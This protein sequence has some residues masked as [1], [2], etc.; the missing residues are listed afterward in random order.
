M[1]ITYVG[2]Q[3]G[4]RAGSTSTTNIT[5]ALSGGS[6]TTP[7]AGDLVVIGCAVGSQGRTP[8][9]AISGYTAG[10]QQDANGTTYDTSLNK[11]Y[12]F[13]GLTPDTTFTLP[14][15]G[16]I[17]DAQRYTVQVW[18]GVDPANPFD[19]ADVVAT[20]TATGRPNPGSITPTT[21]GAVVGIIGAGAAGTGAAYTAPANYTTNFLTGTTADTN[22]AMIGSG[23]RSWTSGAE[24][25][26]AYTGGTTN[27]ADSWAAFT[28]ALRPEVSYEPTLI[29][30]EVVTLGQVAS[31][32]AQNLTVPS[33]AQA[34]VVHFS[35]YAAAAAALSLSSNFAGTFTIVQD[36]GI[37]EQGGVA[38]AVVSSTGA[39]TITPTWGSAPSE[40]PLFFV[41]YIK[42]VDTAASFVRSIKNQVRE[43][44]G[45]TAATV[46]LASRNTD[47]VIALDKNF[48]TSETA[49]GNPSGWTSVATQGN[50]DEGGRLRT[51]DAP[52][53]GK[54]TITGQTNTYSAIM[55]IALRGI[56][57]ATQYTL[58]AQGG[59]YSLTGA[60]ATIS[61]NRQL[62]AQG[63]TYSYTGAQA[64]I[65]YTPFTTQY[66]LT[67]QGGSY[68]LVGSS[69][70][71]SRNR[72]LT[73]QG[74]SY[75][76]AGSS[77]VL[78]K[79]KLLLASGGAYTIASP[80][81]I[82]KRNRTLTAQGGVYAH[83]GS[84]ATLL[85]SRLL[86][87][88]G[89]G[90]SLTGASVGLRRSRSLIA[91][92]GS[93]S[94]T[95]S[96]AQI[97]RN[98]RLTAQ[99]GSYS[100]T[101]QDAT[102]TYTG[103]AVIYTLIAQGGSYSLTGASAGL[104]R[105]RNLTAQ[106]GAYSADGSS[107]TILKSKRLVASGGTYSYT[108]GTAAFLKSRLLIAQGGSYSL[109]GSSAMLSR[110]RRL[111]VIGGTYT[112]TG[113]SAILQKAGG[114]VWPA[115]NQV[116]FGVEYGPTGFEFTGSFVPLSSSPKLDITTGQMV[117]PLTDDIVMTL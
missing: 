116:L 58:T 14:S 25:P 113:A 40:G 81:A 31:P 34:V 13:M 70:T 17:A 99:G 114:A 110:N 74:G 90:Y 107:T 101:G 98:R 15:T 82:I 92:G 27:A 104:R 108:G 49:P 109:L 77:V 89:G 85:K 93:Y 29:S 60:Q 22:D 2:G 66:T 52:N 96:S 50:V 18:R 97:S 1:A 57:T 20:G 106:G 100:Y 45:T 71:L 41:S 63:G 86:I 65:T 46:D 19:V 8:A 51:L 28:Y 78:R 94:L 68:T 6:D 88:S 5:F 32:G 9:C 76:A 7:Q 10:T 37:D 30:T 16:N 3:V 36:A 83:A 39:K 23:Y 112:I 105:N 115:E 33:D 21:S 44:T 64:V 111:Q 103:S 26:A 38:F 47:L 43:D 95:G 42:G 35:C 48:N 56:Q 73:A 59:S 12:K 11:S 62:I 87:A 24:D 79:S 117:L 69:A 91:Q 72:Q 75:A 80:S 61:R 84:S 67:A 54:N 4:G 102:I 55:A 53:D